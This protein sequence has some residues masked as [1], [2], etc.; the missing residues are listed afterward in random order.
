MGAHATRTIFRLPPM[1]YPTWRDPRLAQVAILFSFLVLGKFVLA[2]DVSWLQVVVVVFTVCLLDT[3]LSFWETGTVVVPAS[4]LISGLSL[5]LLLRSPLVW[6]FLVAGVV[7]VLAK[8]LIQVRGRHVFNPSNFGLVVVLV[9]PWA[10]GRVT[11]SQWGR[12]WLIVFLIL[13]LG[14]FLVYAVRRF[15]LVVAFVGSF[16]V[17]GLLRTVL[18][19]SSVASLS[20]SVLSG[21]FLLFTFFMITDPK[22]SPATVRGRVV[23]GV[24]VAAVDALFRVI[25]I[26]YAL[27]LALVTICSVYAV[28]RVLQVDA[29]LESLWRTG[30]TE[31]G[32]IT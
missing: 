1:V 11:P 26:P 10:D 19:V 32:I 31:K 2:F 29:P 16:I 5:S 14:F 18:D 6:P 13:N 4:G 25:G 15:H 3:G 28:A 24:A 21:S 7:T 9:L 22:T 20:A 17:F 8:H 27:F 23:Y 30:S 12:S